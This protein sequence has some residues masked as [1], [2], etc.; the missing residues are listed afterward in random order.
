M[1]R[2]YFL[3]YLLV[4]LVMSLALMLPAQ[5]GQKS[6]SKVNASATATKAGDDG[7]QTV[8]ITLEIAKGW[9]IYANPVGTEDLEGNKTVVTIGA[10]EKVV[11]SV[12]YP[13]GKVKLEKLGKEEVKL[14][15]YEDKVT[16]QAAVTRTMGDSSPLQIS[17]A[18]NACDKNNCLPMGVVK[19]T[20]PSTK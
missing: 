2:L 8:T 17:I 5:A 16:I 13:E 19:L 7:K 10:K 1:N 12:K 15:I 18:V 4:G 6:E 9:H 11:V 3:G 14:R 20:V